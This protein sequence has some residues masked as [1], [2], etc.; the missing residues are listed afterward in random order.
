MNI[1]KT[2]ARKVLKQELQAKEADFNH[3]G[4]DLDRAY[5][6]LQ[7]ARER[8][9]GLES[10]IYQL[11]VQRSEAVAR[12]NE[13]YEKAQVYK[14]QAK[15]MNSQPAVPS[16]ELSQFKGSKVTVADLQRQFYGGLFV[17]QGLELI[18]LKAQK[19]FN[20]YLITIPSGR[21]VRE[22]FAKENLD[23]EYTGARLQI[24]E[25]TK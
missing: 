10:K 16:R 13:W 19:T 24:T 18:E 5:N 21:K 1:F 17:I 3:R 12:G 25:V 6:A 23:P 9:I 11:T 2:L 22:F 4:A 15:R 14:S 8:A 7:V 20:T